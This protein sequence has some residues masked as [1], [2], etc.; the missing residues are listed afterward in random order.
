VINWVGA[1]SD[2]LKNLFDQWKSLRGANLIPDVTLYNQLSGASLTDEVV[3][4][5]VSEGK[6]DLV[7]RFVG[8]GVNEY[9]P[10]LKPELR[11]SSI[12]PH[13]ARARFSAPF[14]KVI[15]ARQPASMFETVRSGRQLV[16]IEKLMLPFGDINQRVR[17]ID[18]V[19]DDFAEAAVLEV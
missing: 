4:V 1:S 18:M 2:K 17:I 8:A 5:L 12:M 19:I 7:T 11:F 14:L 9:F 13:G 6:V 15:K 10:V 3:S 16:D